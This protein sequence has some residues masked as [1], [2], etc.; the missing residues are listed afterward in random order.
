MAGRDE[1]LRMMNKKHLYDLAYEFRNA[2]IWKQVF[3]E[4]LFAVKLPKKAGGEHIAYCCIMGRNGEHMA[5][6]VYPGAEAFTSYRRIASRGNQDPY[7]SL[8]DILIQD[9]IQCSIEQRDQFDPE[10][11]EELKAYCETADLPYRTP[12]PQFKRFF[13][14]GV[15]WEV[16]RESDWAA[17]EAA[18]TIVNQL[19]RELKKQGKSSLGLRPIAMQL[20][21]EAYDT[22]QL[23]LL[24]DL[25]ADEVTIPLYSIK[26]GKLAVE[27]I[28]LP[29]Y[30]EQPL[31]SPTHLNELA[32]AKLMRKK[33]KGEYECEVIRLPKPVDGDPPFTP[34]MLITVDGDGMVL[35][36]VMGRERLYDPDEMINEFIS[37]LGNA[38]PKIIKVRTK[39]TKALMEAFC[40]KAKI[41]LVESEDLDR[42]DEAVNS[43]MEHIGFG[44]DEE[45][46]DES[47]NEMIQTLYEMTLEEIRM[48]PDIVLDGILETAALF[49]PEIIKKIKKARH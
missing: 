45:E 29:P 17:I 32:I 36:P 24:D 8:P 16:S 38:C 10:Q 21:G 35:Q 3:E 9:C 11:L 46:V 27:R 15:P 37:V 31:P 14:Y 6:A 44:K 33:Q 43:L 40:R 41:G 22:E 30:T 20:Y 19:A 48:L 23:S 28:P 4:E 2:K 12:F 13:P 49:P 25:S 7:E 42:L 18:L 26:D 39:E 47:L 1:G 34:A 5:L